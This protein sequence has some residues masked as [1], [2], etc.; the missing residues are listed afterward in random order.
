MLKKNFTISIKLTRLIP[1]EISLLL[2]NTCVLRA[3]SDGENRDVLI[4]YWYC[5]C[6]QETCRKMFSLVL[7]VMT[8]NWKQ[9]SH[10][11]TVKWKYKLEYI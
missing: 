4:G 1:I 5:T 11:F 6:A 9:P 10:Q 2:K 8:P 7:F 3:F